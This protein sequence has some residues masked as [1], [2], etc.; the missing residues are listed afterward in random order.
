MDTEGIRFGIGD[1]KAAPLLLASISS[2]FSSNDRKIPFPRIPLP[3][4][5]FPS[6]PIGG[7]PS[8]S[9]RKNVSPM[10]PD[11]SQ[12]GAEVQ[13]IVALV[14]GALLAHFGQAIQRV[15]LARSSFQPSLK[16]PFLEN[17]QRATETY[18]EPEAL[19]LNLI[20]RGRDYERRLDVRA[21]VQCFEEAVRLTP[22]N[23]VALCFAS[24]MWSDLTFYHDV[25]S[26]R[27][28]QL[29][30]MK[31]LEYSERAIAAHPQHPGGYVS[32][33]VSK[34]RL[35]LFMDNRNKVRLAKEAQEAAE[36]AI[37]Y[38]PD[39]DLAHHVMGRWHYEMS[40]LNPITRTAVRFLYGTT[41]NS[42][43]KEDA[44]AAYNRASDLAP[45]RLLHHAEA[46]RVLFE[47]GRMSAAK[48]R[49]NRALECDVDDINSWQTRM[50]VERLIAMIERRPYR[51][52]SL[53]P[54]GIGATN[55]ST[56]T[57]LGVS[58]STVKGR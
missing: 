30:N 4:L 20:E 40:R 23:V 53:V 57:L 21:A 31:A 33:C 55:L 10:R 35:A 8:S 37:K 11:L 44:L 36:L 12:A 3:G 27:E 16:F 1:E 19:A 29:V 54:P 9:R 32:T 22:S 25:K 52:P 15:S 28:R 26:V 41:L 6:M 45:D 56:A 48:E 39:N 42:G 34:G 2:S 58:E 46:G 14:G 17:H 13:K 38:G 5:A 47:M 18:R 51:Q 7:D 43:T 24:K 50:D 49:L